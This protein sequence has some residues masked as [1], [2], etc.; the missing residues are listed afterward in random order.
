MRLRTIW[1]IGAMTL[2]ERVRRTGT[3]ALIKVAS[4]LPRPLAYWVF[5]VH[6]TRHIHPRE[7]MGDVRYADLA[8]RMH[9]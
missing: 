6:G 3:W 5:V 1:T 8:Q 4:H 9:P 2:A 7:V